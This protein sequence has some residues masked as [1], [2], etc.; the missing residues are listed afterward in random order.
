MRNTFLFSVARAA[1]LASIGG[2]QVVALPAAQADG[3]AES[4][5]IVTA[6][7]PDTH[8]AR[9]LEVLEVFWIDAWDAT[10]HLGGSGMT[11]GPVD[12]GG[13]RTI[14]VHD[15]AETVAT[16]QYQELAR[17][18][19]P[20][21]SPGLPAD[22]SFVFEHFVTAGIA[23]GSTGRA[24]PLYGLAQRVVFAPEGAEP[25]VVEGMTPLGVT[26]TPGAAV[27]AAAELL[28][29]LNADEPAFPESEPPFEVDGDP[30]LCDEVFDGK[31]GACFADSLACDAA[32]G[33]AAI[34]GLLACMM[35]GPGAGPCM[36]AV[37][38]AE[39]LCIAACVG[40]ARACALR[41]RTEWL[42]CWLDCL[43][44]SP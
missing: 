39:A 42:M 30:C 13:P 35:T 37:L 22:G 18:L 32:C 40:R 38:V 43:A 29:L 34:A 4:S 10:F 21:L 6:P 17:W 26:G 31:L 16:G 23:Q 27:A 15:G 20:A 25:T 2:A 5:D 11:L 3:P 41:A 8:R 7:R 44:P 33:A 12:A 1:A 24:L 9:M 14:A 19:V 36:A 28:A